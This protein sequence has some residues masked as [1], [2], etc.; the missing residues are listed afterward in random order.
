MKRIELRGSLRAKLFWRFLNRLINL[1]PP[2]ELPS[3]PVLQAKQNCARGQRWSQSPAHH[4]SRCH[5][6]GSRFKKCSR[7]GSPVRSVKPWIVRLLCI[8]SL[9]A[10]PLALA[11]MLGLG[12]L[13]LARAFTRR[14]DGQWR[15][16]RN[17]YS[18][19]VIGCVR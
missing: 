16:L 8:I 14:T 19:S 4:W 6:R 2:R 18:K 9:A 13:L 7:F 11:S 1:L 10:V 17:R 12:N 3:A 5:H 15:T